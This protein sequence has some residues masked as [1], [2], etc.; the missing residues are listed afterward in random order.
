MAFIWCD[1]FLFLLQMCYTSEEM[2]QIYDCDRNILFY[3]NFYPWN[4]IILLIVG[5]NNAYDFSSGPDTESF[6][7]PF[8]DV[9][10]VLSKN[11][12]FTMLLLRAFGLD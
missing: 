12:L 11:V 3:K 8:L 4:V 6:I 5:M 9:H 7:M 2:K 1:S 10:L